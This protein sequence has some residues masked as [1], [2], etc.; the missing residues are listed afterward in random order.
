MPP[1][2]DKYTKSGASAIQDCDGDGSHVVELKNIHVA[3]YPSTTSKYW[4]AQG[5][6]IDYVAQGDDVEGVKSAFEVGLAATI[7]QHLKSNGDING[8]LDAAPA[9]VRLKALEQ[10]FANPE[11]IKATYSQVSVHDVPV[12]NVEFLTLARAA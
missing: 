3:I 8:F 4:I 11:S 7:H 12:L 2:I 5:F 10:V 1:I 9:D 6:E